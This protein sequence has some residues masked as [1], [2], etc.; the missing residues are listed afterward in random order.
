MTCRRH[1]LVIDDVGDMD[2]LP[3]E[4]SRHVDGCVECEQ[5]GRELIGLRALLREQERVTPP[6]D[7]DVRVAELVRA[8]G[9]SQRGA[10]AWAARHQRPLAAAACIVVA[11]TTA[12]TFRANPDAVPGPIVATDIAI[13]IGVAPTVVSPLTATDAPTPV[14]AREPLAAPAP[15]L[16]ERRQARA[17]GQRRDPSLDEVRIY[18][19]DAEGARVVS[20]D[21][22]IFGAHEILPAA[23]AAAGRTDPGSG[24]SSF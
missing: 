15:R 19:Q 16:A 4:T 12:L 22:V 24:T 17:A 8:H 11:V 18:V 20:F 13:P 2:R 9:A 6:V 3:L 10:W 14:E 7:F 23:V 21:P 5:F 1:Q